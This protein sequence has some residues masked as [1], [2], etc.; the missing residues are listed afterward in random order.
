MPF[1]NNNQNSKYEPPVPGD[2]K[3]DISKLLESKD[4]EMMGNGINASGKLL[5]EKSLNHRSASIV[6]INSKPV[7]N[8][9][10][11]TRRS[12]N[13]RAILQGKVER[14]EDLDQEIRLDEKIV[15]SELAQIERE[16]NKKKRKRIKAQMNG[17]MISPDPE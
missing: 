5:D 17:Q 7:L 14:P 3:L 12:H 10:D 1:D 4:M 15:E 8:F 13:M 16:A 9:C 11:L 6:C 2:L